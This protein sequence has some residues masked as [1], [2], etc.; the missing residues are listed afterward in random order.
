M[1]R[2]ATTPIQ[3]APG[4]QC[5]C[6]RL[7]HV[8]ALQTS[9]GDQIPMTM[10]SRGS[11]TV[12]CLQVGQSTEEQA[13]G[14]NILGDAVLT[15][16]TMAPIAKF[17]KGDKVCICCSGSSPCGFCPCH[18]LRPRPANPT[19][20]LQGG[21]VRVTLPTRSLSSHDSVYLRSIDWLDWA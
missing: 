8:D 16:G 9:L 11:E 15:G 3:E 20:S 4:L 5:K 17:T 19:L 2:K 13:D 12:E 18:L 7:Q 10:Q 1:K 21:G 6:V 14:S